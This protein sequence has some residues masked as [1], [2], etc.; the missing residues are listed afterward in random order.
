MP[1]VP[2]LSRSSCCSDLSLKLVLAG[3]ERSSIL[4]RVL[5]TSTAQR[6]ASADVSW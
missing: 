1:G 2:L 3:T 5:L 4:L 6:P